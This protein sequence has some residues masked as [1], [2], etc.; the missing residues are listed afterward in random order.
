MIDQLIDGL[1]STLKEEKD[2]SK[3]ANAFL[4][5]PAFHPEFFQKCRSVDLPDFKGFLEAGV[6]SALKKK[7]EITRILAMQYVKKQLIHGMFFANEG[8]GMF[9][10]YT[11]MRMGLGAFSAEIQH[12]FRMTLLAIPMPAE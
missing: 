7:V 12:F 8:S 11:D 2:L 9:F 5:I 3:I 10:Y 6:S 1:R 4:D